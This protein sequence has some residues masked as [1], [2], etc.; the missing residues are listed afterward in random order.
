MIVEKASVVKV[1][2]DQVV[3]SAKIK[4]TCNACDVQSDC[5]TGTIARAL[6][7]REQQLTIKT[8]V[9]VTVG[10]EVNVGIPEQSVVS[11]SMWLYLVPLLALIA[12]ALGLHHVLQSL[13]IYHELLV[14]VGANLVTFCVFVWVSHHL[15]QKDKSSFQPVI[16]PSRN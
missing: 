6:A 5:G 11:A 8:P 4:T 10:Q 1:N 12:S 3:V 7:P 2:G 16:L 15:K 9:P 14:L 13:G